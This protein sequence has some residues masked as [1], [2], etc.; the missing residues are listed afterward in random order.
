M[1]DSHLNPDPAS[2]WDC[3]FQ[4]GDCRIKEIAAGSDLHSAT[5]DVPSWVVG[6]VAVI[7]ILVASGCMSLEQMAPPV[8]R[9]V[10]AGD[11]SQAESLD[12]GRRIYTTTCAKC[13][14]VEPVARYS[15]TRWK[16]ILVDMGEQARLGAEQQADLAAYVLAARRVVEQQGAGR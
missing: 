15:L 3:R 2:K 9:I 1:R 8:E 6:F 11:S 7:W 14:A 12:R 16:D 5:P 13:H 4:I 10:A